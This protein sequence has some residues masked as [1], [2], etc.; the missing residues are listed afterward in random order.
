M[1]LTMVL[2]CFVFEIVFLQFQIILITFWISSGN[3]NFLFFFYKNY[4]THS[5]DHKEKVLIVHLER[6]L[7]KRLYAI[8]NVFLYQ[9]R[10]I[11]KE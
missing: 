5:H 10:T 7:I 6:K 3:Q 4:V 2:V 1:R 8:K 11:N 9:N